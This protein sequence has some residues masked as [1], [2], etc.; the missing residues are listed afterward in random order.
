MIAGWFAVD[1]I[2]YAIDLF[3][4]RGRKQ[5][6]IAAWAALGNVAVVLLILFA[7]GWLLTW[8]VAIAGALRI[9]GIAWNIIVAPVF[10]T[11]EA[12][13][14]VVDELGL[15]DDPG[16]CG[17]GRRDRGRRA[18]ARA[19]RSRLDAVVHRDAVRDSHRPHEHRL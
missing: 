10:T 16:A 19:H 13:E 12:D 4:S 1:A 14:T 6:S 11:A 17:D 7:R 8:V 5:R 3:R 15:A 9:F 2:R 18:H